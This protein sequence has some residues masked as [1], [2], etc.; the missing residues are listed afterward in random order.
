LPLSAVLV[1]VAVFAAGV[2]VRLVTHRVRANRTTG[3]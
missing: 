2:L 1:G 3:S